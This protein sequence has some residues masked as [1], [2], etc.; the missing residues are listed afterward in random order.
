VGVPAG[1]TRR[2][3][4][5][6]ARSPANLYEARTEV[7]HRQRTVAVPGGRP[8]E[9]DALVRVSPAPV[10]PWA[11]L[12]NS[13]AKWSCARRTRR[14]PHGSIIVLPTATG[15]SAIALAPSPTRSTFFAHGEKRDFY[16]RTRGLAQPDV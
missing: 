14:D 9:S 15:K 11:A 6:R 5:L 3:A 2:A 12:A 16:S 10:N 4:R 8:Y 1:A 13:E 7:A